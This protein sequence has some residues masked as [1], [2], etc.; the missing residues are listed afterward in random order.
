MGDDEAKENEARKRTD[1]AAGSRKVYVYEY[2][3][4]KREPGSCIELYLYIRFFQGYF[5]NY[6]IK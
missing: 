4:C 3:I 1:L 2:S 6:F 5:G